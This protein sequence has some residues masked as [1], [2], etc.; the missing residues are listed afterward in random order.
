MN[1][2][3]AVTGTAIVRNYSDHWTPVHL[4]IGVDNLDDAIIKAKLF[5]AKMS[6]A[7]S[8][9]LFG[10]LAPMRDPFGHGFCL[11]EFNEAGDDACITKQPPAT[12]PRA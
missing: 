7:I 5:G 11:I 1:R 6:A 2:S 3:A 4:D 12:Q 8:S 9:Q 10:R